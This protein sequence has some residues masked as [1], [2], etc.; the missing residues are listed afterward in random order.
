MPDVNTMR[1]TFVAKTTASEATATL[2]RSMTHTSGVGT[3][4]GSQCSKSSAMRSSPSMRVKKQRKLAIAVTAV[5]TRT[6]TTGHF[7][8]AVCFRTA[9]HCTLYR[10][11]RAPAMPPMPP[12]TAKPGISYHPHVTVRAL[13]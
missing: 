7:L 6:S 1:A 5:S 11:K 3:S 2:D 10:M 12:T 13:V 9:H 8:S 4:D